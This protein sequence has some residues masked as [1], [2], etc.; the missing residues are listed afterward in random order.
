MFRHA[1]GFQLAN[2]GT[3]TRTLQAY[4]GHRNIVSASRIAM[5]RTTTSTPVTA[6]SSC[7]AVW[8]EW[9][10]LPLVSP[11][12]VFAER[13]TA[14][15]TLQSKRAHTS[16]GIIAKAEALSDEILIDDYERHGEIA[17]SFAA[18]VLRYFG[19]SIN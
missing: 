2:Q 5:P 12:C 10:A 4:L 15:D 9:P 17:V 11:Q 19:V 13:Y 1:C 7:A 16:N 8:R 14:L 18:D 3:D 6:C